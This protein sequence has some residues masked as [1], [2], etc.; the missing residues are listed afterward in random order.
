MT[1]VIYRRVY[2][3]C[4][5]LQLHTQRLRYVSC[6]TQERKRWERIRDDHL[7]EN[8]IRGESGNVRLQNPLWQKDTAMTHAAYHDTSA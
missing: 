8:M 4:R 5:T 2:P 3:S 6:M 7:C 1:D